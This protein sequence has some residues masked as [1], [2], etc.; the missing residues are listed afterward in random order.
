MNERILEVPFVL[1]ALNLPSGSRVLDVGSQWSLLP[2]HLAALGYRTVATDLAPL[3]IRG[4]GADDVVADLRAAPFRSGSFDGATM[5]S[6]LEHIGIGF[7][8]DRKGEA[9]DAVVMRELRRIVRPGGFLVLTVPYGR[10]GSGPLQRAYDQNRLRA[11]TDEWTWETVRYFARFGIG[12]R[13]VPEQEAA[14]AESAL[15]TSA[16]A[17]LCLRRP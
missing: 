14:A 8:D 3:S 10:G 12:W 5:M 1:R 9:D 4:A 2:L 15:E 11:V 13:E 6:T 16:V 17:A 7:Y